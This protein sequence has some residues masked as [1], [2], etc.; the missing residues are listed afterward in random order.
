[1]IWFSCS[2]CGRAL[3]R[4]EASAGAFIFCSCGQGNVVP[5]D[6]TIAAPPEAGPAETPPSQ[7][8]PLRPVPV[9]EERIPAA[10]RP[11]PL[12]PRDQDDD[13]QTRSSSAPAVRSAGKCFNHQDRPVLEKCEAC[14]EGFCA[15]CL[16]HF[17]GR[18]LCGPCK[19]LRLRGTDRP[20][21]VS[22]KAWIAVALAMMAGPGV[23]CLWPFGASGVVLLLCMLA[24]FAQIGAVVL[25]VV[26]LRETEAN[27]RLGGRALAITSMLTGGLASVL[28]IGFVVFGPK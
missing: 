21:T 16:L 13:S 3:G 17:Q 4:P 12:P 24:L 6:S 1:M 9:G 14:S 7:P 15:D 28:T 25:G 20:G 23:S 11:P 27:P 10:R 22:N 2:Q 5:W 26:A 19:N 8:P 18:P